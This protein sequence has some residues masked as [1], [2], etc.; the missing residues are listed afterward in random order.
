MRTSADLRDALRRLRRAPAL[1]VATIGTLALSIGAT[2]AVF[3]VVS[4]VLL[5]PL[6]LPAEDRL[7]W[8]DHSGL[9][10]GAERGLNLTQGL[11]AHYRTSSRTL[12]NIAVY[13][14]VDRNVVADGEPE[15]LDVAMTSA[16]FA[17]T[18]ALSPA[19]GRYFT[20]DED[21]PGARR[22]AVLSDGFWRRRFGA[23]PAVIGQ[24]VS[25]DGV[26][27]E[28]L[29]VMPAAMNYPSRETSLWIPLA[30]EPNAAAFGSFS[31]NG[32]ARLSAGA[33]VASAQRELAALLPRVTETYPS[34]AAMLRETRLQPLVVP[35]RDH[36][37]GD[38]ERTLWILMTAVALVLAVAAANLTGL[39][40]V[41]AESRQ[42]DLA[43]RVALGAGRPTIFRHLFAES[44]L[45]SVTGGGLGLTIG[46]WALGMLRAH[47]PADLPRREEIGISPAVWSVVALVVVVM[48][49][50]FTLPPLLQKTRIAKVLR[51]SGRGL[52]NSRQQLLGRHALVAGQVALAV[53]LMIGAGLMVQSFWRVRHVDTGFQAA[54]VLTF[55]LGLSKDVYVTSDRAIAAQ[56]AVLERLRA[57]PGVEN[58]GTT[59]C[60]PLCGRWA[61]D[62]WAAEDQPAASGQPAPVGATRAVS[63]TYLTTLGVRLIAGRTLTAADEGPTARNVVISQ[64]L[65]LRLWPNANAVGRR[66]SNHAASDNIW[67]TVVG[68]VANTAVRQAT[69]DP[70]PMVYLPVGADPNGPGPWQLAVAV[71]VHGDPNALAGSIRRAVAAVDPTLAVAHLRTLD[72]IVASADARLALVTLLLGGAALV[73]LLLGVLGTYGVLAFVVSRRVPEFGL[74]LA[75]GASHAGIVAMLVRQGGIMVGAGLAMGVVGALALSGALRT[76]L[77]GVSPLDP[78]TFAGACLLLAAAALAA[79]YIPARRAG[80]A[81]PT[82]L[83]RES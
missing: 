58:A 52:T 17:A 3:G 12:S 20:N 44:L 27:Y 25:I 19:L 42:R 62:S 53:M 5:H 47:G 10:I 23:N 60:L 81:D 83:L 9:G 68:V 63:S 79:I 8:L 51:D 40:L 30:L 32:V 57:I 49:V 21:L 14:S 24:A 37:V 80:R 22:V 16:T 71:K 35:L 33:T 78:A 4:G 28:V 65:A 13:V 43:V 67:Y 56:R 11:Y 18:L 46:W 76:L 74:R 48:A 77:F 26:P 70:A 38:V 7:V 50:L 75:L 36:I 39:F 64:Q 29:G 72:D 61:G 15:R 69:E 34:A 2:T 59:T 31:L 41:R 82:T 54:Q 55:E 45:L 6:P 73:A 1:T 66:L